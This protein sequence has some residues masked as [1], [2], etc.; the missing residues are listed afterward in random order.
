MIAVIFSFFQL[1]FELQSYLS[2]SENAVILKCS[3]FGSIMTAGLILLY[4]LFKRTGPLPALQ[5]PIPPFDVQTLLLLFA[6]GFA[7]GLDT[8]PKAE[9]E[10]LNQ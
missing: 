1:A 3:V 6:E 10:S 8:K 7:R 2:L 9:N 5:A 4:L